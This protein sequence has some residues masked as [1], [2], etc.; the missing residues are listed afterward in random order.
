MKYLYALYP[1]TAVL[2]FLV[3]TGLGR[4]Y[5]WLGDVYLLVMGFGLVWITQQFSKKQSEKTGMVYMSLSLVRMFLGIGVVVM[6][7]ALR[8]PEGYRADAL[9]FVGL[10]VFQIAVETGVMVRSLRSR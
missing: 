9:V 2:H 8:Q 7:L 1:L 6:P 4:T 5:F 10:F 3:S